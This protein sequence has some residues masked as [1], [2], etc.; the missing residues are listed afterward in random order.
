MVSPTLASQL[1]KAEHY[2]LYQWHRGADDSE[3][4]AVPLV[5]HGLG[6]CLAWMEPFIETLN[7]H[8]PVVA[9]LDISLYGPS[10]TQVGHIPSRQALLAIIQQGIQAVYEQHNK[11]V[12]LIGLSLGGLL[13]THALARSA[14]QQPVAGVV[15]VSP[16]FKA[17]SRSFRPKTYAQ[18]LMRSWVTRSSS[19]IGLPYDITGITSDP[20]QQS[21]LRAATGCVTAMTAPSF[22]ELLK[23]TISR[24]Q[25]GQLNYPLLL[26]RADE[27]HI[28]DTQAMDQEWKRW[29][30]KQKQ[31]VVF[32]NVKHD[33]VLEPVN[34]QMATMI[35]GWQQHLV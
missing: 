1:H 25:F 34:R 33:L 23:L 31:L 32:A 26:M 16:A 35:W 27:D 18:V 9:G 14:Y 13:V 11:P 10:E 8:Y 19:P 4:N 24:R 29:P 22:L 15:L 12:L 17:S 3:Y 20:E 6:G 5:V 21:R 7:Q 30:N 28:C 2:T